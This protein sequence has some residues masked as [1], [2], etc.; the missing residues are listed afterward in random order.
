MDQVGGDSPGTERNT[1]RSWRELTLGT[2]GRGN[3]GQGR[4][5]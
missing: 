1:K 5:Q 2:P 3:A 4:F